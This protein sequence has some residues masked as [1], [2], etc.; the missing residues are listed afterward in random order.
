MIRHIR[1]DAVEIFHNQVAAWGLDI[2]HNFLGGKNHTI[3][4]KPETTYTREKM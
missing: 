3:V 1:I 4:N 2:F